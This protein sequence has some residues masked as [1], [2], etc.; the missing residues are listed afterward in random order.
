MLASLEEL[1]ID[2]EDVPEG[3]RASMNG[4]VPANTTYYQWLQRQNAAVQ[5]EVLGPRRY[6]MWKNGDITIDKFHNERGRWLTLDQ[7][8]RRS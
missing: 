1:G 7:L 5:R 6:D 3:Q 2:I 4:Q 8:K